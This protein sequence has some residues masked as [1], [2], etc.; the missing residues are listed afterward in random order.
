MAADMDTTE[1]LKEA[2]ALFDCAGDGKISPEELAA[3]TN[4][5]S[6]FAGGSGSSLTVDEA[7]RLIMPS[8]DATDPADAEEEPKDASPAARNIV[9]IA[10]PPGSGKGSQA[11]L[12][13]DTLGIPQLSTGDMLR[14]E[15][16]AETALGKQA[17][18]IM[19]AGGLVPDELVMEVLGKRIQ[20]DDCSEGFLLDGFPRTVGQAE[21]LDGVLAQT[22]EGVTGMIT[23][24]VPDDVLV[25]R[26]VGRWI[27]RGSGR[28]YHQKFAPPQSARAV[29]AA[30]DTPEAH[31]MLDD[32]TG[33]P[34]T[35]RDDDNEEALVARLV[36]YHEQTTPVVDYFSAKESS[37][38]KQ[39]NAN[40]DMDG[41]R[42]LIRGATSE[43]AVDKTPRS[44]LARATGTDSKQ[45]WV[46]ANRTD[47]LVQSVMVPKAKVK[48]VKKA[49]AEQLSMNGVVKAYKG[50]EEIEVRAGSRA[51]FHVLP[52]HQYLECDPTVIY[53]VGY[54]HQMSAWV[55]AVSA[56][57]EDSVVY[58]SQDEFVT[59]MQGKELQAYFP[60]AQLSKGVETIRS[61]RRVFDS[62]D[63]ENNDVIQEYELLGFVRA[64]HSKGATTN[65]ALRAAGVDLAAV[66][67][68]GHEIWRVLDRREDES[69]LFK[70][71]LEGIVVLAGMPV[72]KQYFQVE[73]LTDTTPAVVEMYTTLQRRLTAVQKYGWLERVGWGWFAPDFFQLG[74]ATQEGT[75]VVPDDNPLFDSEPPQPKQSS[76]FEDEAR[77][78]GSVGRTVWSE[79]DMA[80]MKS[81]SNQ[82]IVRAAM[83]GAFITALA[84]PGVE[85]I[86]T[87]LGHCTMRVD[88]VPV[89]ECGDDSS[90]VRGISIVLS[91][92]L[93]L[94]EVLAVC[95]VSV[96]ATNR[97]AVLASF[98]ADFREQ[99][100]CVTNGLV[101]AGMG[102]GVQP[103]SADLGIYT[104]KGAGAVEMIAQSILRAS[105]HYLGMMLGRLAVR[106][107]IR[108]VLKATLWWVAP[109]ADAI[110]CG[111]MAYFCMREARLI[112]TG[113]KVAQTTLK[114]LGLT[115]HSERLNECSSA[116]LLACMRAVSLVCVCKSS[117][118]PTHEY[119][120]RCILRAQGKRLYVQENGTEEEQ[121]AVKTTDS[122]SRDTMPWAYLLTK[123]GAT[124][125]TAFFE[126]KVC[127]ENVELDELADFTTELNDMLL[128]EQEIVLKVLALAIVTDAP[129]T[130]PYSFSSWRMEQSLSKLYN[131]SVRSCRGRF[132]ANVGA[133]E[134]TS[135]SLAAG[136]AVD[137][138]AFTDIVTGVENTW[139]AAHFSEEPSKW[140]VRFNVAFLP[141]SVQTGSRNLL[142]L[143]FFES[144]VSL[145]IFMNTGM[146]GYC[147]PT[148]RNQSSPATVQ[149][150][151]T[152]DVL[153]T[154]MYSLEIMARIAAYGMYRQTTTLMPTFFGSYY[155][156]LDLSVVALAYCSYII[157]FLGIEIEGARPNLF[158]SLRVLRLVHSV[159]FFASTR[160]IL[161]ALG[162]AA[163]YLSNVVLLFVF[164][165]CVYG[166]LGISLYGGVL[167]ITCEDVT[168]VT[169]PLAI[170]DDW[171]GSVGDYVHCPAS[172]HCTPNQACQ[173]TSEG[174]RGGYAGFD[175]LPYAILTLISTTTG[176]NWNEI[177]YALMDT[178]ANMAAYAIPVMLSITFLLT[179]VAL[180]IFVAII[181]AVFADVRESSEL[182]AFTESA[183]LADYLSDDS[184]EE[185]DAMD[186]LVEIG[187]DE[188]LNYSVPRGRNWTKPP[189]HIQLFD[190]IIASPYFDGF[191][192]LAIIGNTISLT[193]PHFGMTDAEHD[194]ISAIEFTF[195][196]LFVIEMF[197]KI[198]GL[199]FARYWSVGWNKMDFAVNNLAM[200]ETLFGASADGEWPTAGRVLR[201]MRVLRAARIARLLRKSDSL[202]RLFDAVSQSGEA[203]V[204]LFVFTMFCLA[205]FALFGMHM[206]GNP[207]DFD[208]EGLEW[209]DEGTGKANTVPRP[210]FDTVL[211]SFTSCFLMM[212]GDR[213][214]VTMYTYMQTHGW[215]VALFFVFLWML[216]T[217]VMLNL[218]VAVILENFGLDDKT[219]VDKQKVIFEE[220]L[221]PTVNRNWWNELAMK[222]P[223]KGSLTSLE[224]KHGEESASFF[225]FSP[226]NPFRVACTRLRVSRG[227]EILIMLVIAVSA[228]MVAYEGAPGSLSDDEQLVV[229][230]MDLIF[231][232]LFWIE[233]FVRSVSRGFILTKNAYITNA[234][235]KIDLVVIILC[236]LGAM[237]P[238]MKELQGIVKLG[239]LLRPLRLLDQYEG[240]HIIFVALTMAFVDLAG[241]IFLQLVLLII[242]GIVGINL[243][244]GLFYRCDNGDVF[245]QLD[246]VGTFV[247]SGGALTGPMWD[248]PGFSF[249]SIFDAMKTLF[250]VSTGSGWSE[251]LYVAMDSTQVGMQPRR[252]AFPEAGLFFVVFIFLSSFA[253]IN[254]FIG[255]LIH[256]FGIASGAG[257]HTSAQRKWSLMKI[258]IAQMRPTN[259]KA[260]RRAGMRGVV[261]DIVTHDSF[262]AAVTLVILVNIGTMLSNTTPE[263]QWW[264]HGLE[265]VN[266]CCLIAFTLEG[267]LKIY[268]LSWPTYWRDSW[269]RLDCTIVTASWLVKAVD[270]YLADEIL[271]P[272]VLQILRCLRV[273][274]LVL[275]LKQLPGLRQVFHTFF[276]SLPEVGEIFV[277]LSLVIFIYACVGMFLFGYTAGRG[278][279]P[280]GSMGQFSN[281]PDAVVLLV[282]IATGMDM[283]YI[284]ADLETAPPYCTPG[285]VGAADAAIAHGDCGSWLAFPY[286]ASYYILS[287][288]LLL[289]MIIAII[290]E[291]FESSKSTDE[292]EVAPDDMQHYKNT[293]HGHV[294][295]KG[296]TELPYEELGAF[297][298]DLGEPLGSPCKPIPARWLNVVLHQVEDM[299]PRPA[300]QRS[301]GFT[302]MLMTLT[303]LTMGTECLS[304]EEMY[305]LREHARRDRAAKILKCSVSAWHRK[306]N[307]PPD[308]AASYGEILG[309]AR[310]FRLHYI[311]FVYKATGKKQNLGWDGDVDKASKAKKTD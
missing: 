296:R 25:E 154:V 21:A 285:V 185:D 107:V 236:T 305:H 188:N 34:L 103:S 169:G 242:F 68:A 138:S 104:A 181:G 31:Q 264:A 195:L 113:A 1:L 164:F 287:E 172:I 119:I 63:V 5:M 292:L 159:R 266:L 24:N 254:L 208:K 12:I 44:P 88:T 177:A 182:S 259:I 16:A 142:R 302:E 51:P 215:S 218:F 235:N 52:D 173:I 126:S 275:L 40:Q 19:D 234:W 152:V 49:C 50:W 260:R 298:E 179:L 143:K 167:R 22:D 149:F 64:M 133:M 20:Q 42:E 274:R 156:V 280:Y 165:F 207:L 105:R 198:C 290:M 122:R 132:P 226:T 204:N 35:Q 98:K 115:E 294:T 246:C 271:P 76:M 252:D 304:Y 6:L 125:E 183:G 209:L 66:S 261:Y 196:V 128:E 161:T 237:I 311:C 219:K 48:Y 168:N 192:T 309:A 55:G 110:W 56:L 86:A 310:T 33:E 10:G 96:R 23:L 180:N 212:T 15:V 46:A 90:R 308:A 194:V 144:A 137:S 112:C 291:H 238:E 224:E 106:V 129:R 176:D 61:L 267:A 80:Q 251:I 221:K 94:I 157:D 289:N 232:S 29:V 102:L 108:G 136:E 72:G 220:S 241:I 91:I 187:W 174:T 148:W 303:V 229:Q 85:G 282:Q 200:F 78:Q 127:I 69:V 217:C 62:I 59:L 163:T 118:H 270:T 95:W 4:A 28:S 293:W 248:N 146:L 272:G 36:V 97:M 189:Y 27:H 202:Q 201:L 9:I 45:V 288:F 81:L 65:K 130:F 77:E 193:Y 99:R 178:D 14:G 2:F 190:M 41:V 17:A 228:A 166:I 160:A 39:V 268:G 295:M 54:P 135:R 8:Y 145:L 256:V 79:E 83:I 213:W 283:V 258:L 191:V 250:V 253:V 150:V 158:R 170:H 206:L 117:M 131:E 255:V 227:F 214:K 92:L 93:T 141:F 247:D 210:I 301:V 87:A 60:L 101:R 273:I 139:L 82:V 233:C 13:C 216:C 245:G 240:M 225:I 53:K 277:L 299:W 151:D 140:S 231:L 11:Q 262:E 263:P 70:E 222:S 230:S 199:G 239:R 297:L 75:L 121:A 47:R 278:L 26:V 223:L 116:M 265:L 244:M 111:L 249:D 123:I 286:L 211:N 257:L 269:N 109:F 58:L 120:L 284:F 30:G 307:P 276:V 114:E 38:V 162:R 124:G 100:A 203:V 18:D 84:T 300:D 134:A 37:L 71:F 306:N 279:S 171:G 197:I 155:N 32:E 73:Q 147:S 243:F 186:D 57:G 153:F 67:E 175:S 74:A 281:F 7:T 3:V 89:V 43:L 205:V 184:S